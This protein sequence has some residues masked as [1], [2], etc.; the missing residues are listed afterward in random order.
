LLSVNVLSNSISA[1]FSF[2]YRVHSVLS[3]LSRIVPNFTSPQPIKPKKASDSDFTIEDLIL[4][5]GMRFS[6][7]SQCKRCSAGRLHQIMAI[8]I[9]VAC[10]KMSKLASW[11]LTARAYARGWG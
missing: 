6:L 7:R 4:W 11:K 10:T 9:K 2:Y 8:H 3:Q 1:D 5:P